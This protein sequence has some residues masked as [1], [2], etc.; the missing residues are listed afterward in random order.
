MRSAACSPGRP[1]VGVEGPAQRVGS[2]GKAAASSGC[3]AMG[4]T[5]TGPPPASKIRLL[6]L[7]DVEPAEPVTFSGLGF[8]GVGT[9]FLFSLVDEVELTDSTSSAR[10]AVTCQ[11][12]QTGRLSRQGRWLSRQARR[13]RCAG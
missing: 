5:T 1:N 11:R 4:C 8:S 2:E 12:V 6:L 3:G 13:A 9:F 7:L 10:P